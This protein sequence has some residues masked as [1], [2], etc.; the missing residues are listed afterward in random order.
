VQPA[1]FVG[2]PAVDEVAGREDEVGA[3]PQPEEVLDGARKVG[4]RIDTPV[5]EGALGLD[6]R[7]GD[8]GDQHVAE[9]GPTFDRGPLA[10]W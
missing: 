2:A 7:V 10:G 1:I 4:R 8:L 6:V 9:Y 3:R 5:R